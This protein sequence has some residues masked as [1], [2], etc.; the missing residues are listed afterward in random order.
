MKLTENQLKQLIKESVKKVLSEIG[1]HEKQKKASKDEHD[2]WVIRM[3]KY[4][5]AY[6]DSKKKKDD[7]SDSIDYKDYKNG[8]VFTL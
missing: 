7:D 4:K 1:Y 2:D 6:N 8:K 3:S 5:K